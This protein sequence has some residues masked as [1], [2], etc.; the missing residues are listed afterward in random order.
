MN[1][2]LTNLF[3]ESDNQLAIVP[4]DFLAVVNSREKLIELQRSDST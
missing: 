2:Y 1:T 4:S 3:E